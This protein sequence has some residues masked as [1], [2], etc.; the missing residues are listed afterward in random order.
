VAPNRKR[1]SPPALKPAALKDLY[2]RKARALHRRPELARGAGYTRVRL[3]EAGLACQVEGDDG[4]V[5][6]DLRVDLAP[7]DGGT[8]TAAGPGDLLR[9][10]LG[11]CLAMDYRLWAARLDVPIGAVEIDLTVEFDARG[12]LLA[13]TDIRPGWRRLTCAVTI[14]SAAPAADVARVVDVA[15]ARCPVLA[16]QSPAIERVHALTVVLP[17]PPPTERERSV[18]GHAS[19]DESNG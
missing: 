17:T 3:P 13:E 10:S 18:T 16:N 7:A 5:R 2:E 4:Q 14:H 1:A 19:G 9:A 6:G 11:A 15:N 8:G 12:A